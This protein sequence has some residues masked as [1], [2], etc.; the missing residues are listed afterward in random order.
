[1]CLDNYLIKIQWDKIKIWS[2]LLIALQI[3]YDPVVPPFSEVVYV[4]LGG[5]FKRPAFKA[6]FLCLFFP[7]ILEFFK[8][9]LA[10]C[11]WYFTHFVFFLF[12]FLKIGSLL[13]VNNYVSFLKLV[14]FFKISFC[15]DLYIRLNWMGVSKLIFPFGKIWHEV[16]TENTR[17]FWED[18]FF[19]PAHW[20]GAK[21]EGKKQLNRYQLI[22][23]TGHL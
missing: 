13:G 21:S 17:M 22:N 7:S 19:W 3:L 15:W 9:R 4:Y 20:G 6:V 2:E 18:N 16:Y 5:S 11:A 14:C 12:F 10:F 23:W 8:L 1:M